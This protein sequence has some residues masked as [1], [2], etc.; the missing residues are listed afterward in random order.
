MPITINTLKVDLRK[1]STHPMPEFETSL[2]P[3]TGQVSE[4]R[5]H[6]KQK[7]ARMPLS[8]RSGLDN[9]TSRHDAVAYRRS[10]FAL[11]NWVKGAL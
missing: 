4:R 6:Q 8:A 7:P 9:A 10:C 2:L 11:H 1:A 3:G 5:I